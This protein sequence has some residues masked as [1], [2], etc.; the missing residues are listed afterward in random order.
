MG[1]KFYQGR[2]WESKG[3]GSLEEFEVGFG[4]GFFKDMDPE[5]LLAML[6]TWRSTRCFSEE[7]CKV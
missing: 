4:L 1:P 2:V 6:R 5:D 7:E 3:F